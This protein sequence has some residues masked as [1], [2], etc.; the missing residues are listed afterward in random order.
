MQINRYNAG[1]AG[2]TIVAY[3]RDSKD[4]YIPRR[5]REIHKEFALRFEF[6]DDAFLLYV[7]I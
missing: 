3:P 1:R 6:F 7:H 2:R 4:S 5:S